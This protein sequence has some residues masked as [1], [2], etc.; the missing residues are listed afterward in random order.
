MGV[1]RTAGGDHSPHAARL[2]MIG[3]MVIV[4]L[5]RRRF[6]ALCGAACDCNCP[7]PFL[8]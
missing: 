1:A 3:K 2:S 5:A 8:A 7:Y 4:N 6:P